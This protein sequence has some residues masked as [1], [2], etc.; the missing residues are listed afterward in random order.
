MRWKAGRRG[1]GGEV[2]PL[3]RETVMF[4]VRSAGTVEQKVQKI[5]E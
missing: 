4:W 2:F 1:E 5:R 3:V